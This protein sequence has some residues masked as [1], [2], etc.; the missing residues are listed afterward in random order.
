MYKHVNNLFTTLGWAVGLVGIGYAIG[1][2]NKLSKVSERLNKGIDDL[3]DNME[4]DIPQELINKAVD[5]AVAA[6]AKRAVQKA[7]TEAL[8]ELKRDIRKTV[9]TEVEKEYATIKDSVLQEVTDA[10]AR[11]DVARVRRDVEKAAEKAALE[12]FQVNLDDQLES[13]NSNLESTAKVYQAISSMMAPAHNT[14]QAKE[15]VFR[16]G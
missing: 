8:A 7:T 10:A 1:T 5:S 2:H 13:F 16:V 15:Y 11:I 4:I 6:E 3:A 12:K 14:N 9:S